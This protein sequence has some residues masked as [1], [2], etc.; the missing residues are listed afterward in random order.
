M[1]EIA[2]SRVWAMPSP[3]TFTIKPVRE[4]IGR[5]TIVTV[6]RKIAAELPLRLSETEQPAPGPNGWST[7]AKRRS[8]LSTRPLAEEVVHLPSEGCRAFDDSDAPQVGALG[9][10]AQEGSKGLPWYSR[11]PT[12]G[13]DRGVALFLDSLHPPLF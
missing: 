5:F 10:D 8:P 1:S 4:L 3:Q 7:T 13:S 2:L 11:R 9:A 12:S 6:G